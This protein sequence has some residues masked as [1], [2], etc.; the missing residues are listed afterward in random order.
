MILY[1]GSN[2]VV[3][4]IDLGKCR[5]FK[6]F[7]RG[8]YTTELKE[9]ALTM[10]K[11]T[12]RMFGGS[13][14]M[15]EF[16]LDESIFSDKR[17]HVKKFM[18]PSIEWATFVI[19]NRNKDYKDIANLDCNS[20]NK[21][22]VVIGPVANDDIMVTLEVYIDGRLTPSGLLDALLYKYKDLTQQTSFHSEKA[23]SFLTR[24]N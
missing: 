16:I 21:Y 5:P 6:D 3:D 22:D 15:S 20:D 7:G 24:N 19:N 9:Q 2:C 12:A 10:A 1:H 23:L 4:K 13:P 11:R 18:E 14:V 8:F 17:V